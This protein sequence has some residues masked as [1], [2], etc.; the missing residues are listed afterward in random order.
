MADTA[1]IKRKVP[2][3]R[4]LPLA[5]LT[6][7]MTLAMLLS[8]CG[9]AADPAA[10]AG[11]PRI[12]GTIEQ[13]T[14]TAALRRLAEF[15]KLRRAMAATGV[16]PRLAAREP[17]TLLAPR[18]NA[19]AQLGSEAQ[20]ALFAPANSAALTVQLRNLIL[21]R[22][23]RAEEIKTMIDEGGGVA[24]LTAMGGA[25]ISFTREGDQLVAT[26]PNGGRATMGT[27]EASAGNGVFYVIDH[28]PG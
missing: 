19:F 1:L 22:T 28:W 25:T 16:A 27:Q 13:P 2:L 4:A 14:V 17:L 23:V 26:W 11:P 18:D 6:L 7:A 20:A 10:T 3:R 24:R 15:T 12:A 8:G 9:P 5:P 21:P